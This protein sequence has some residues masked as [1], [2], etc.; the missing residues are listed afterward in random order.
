MRKILCSSQVS[1]TVNCTK[2]VFPSLCS[3]QYI[4]P[5]WGGG[6]TTYVA[7]RLNKLARCPVLQNE[8]SKIT[9]L[10]WRLTLLKR[11]T[12]LDYNICILKNPYL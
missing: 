12:F 9:K 7:L 1:K 10:L 2:I 11:T 4:G 6:S 3:S 5:T 8:W